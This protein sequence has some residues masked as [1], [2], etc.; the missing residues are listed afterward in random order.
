MKQSEAIVL[1]EKAKSVSEYFDLDLGD[2][3]MFPAGSIYKLYD[4]VQKV[5][6]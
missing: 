3:Y 4:Y 2:V 5:K 1:T 6:K